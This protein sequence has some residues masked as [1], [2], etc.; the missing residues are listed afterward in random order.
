[1]INVDTGVIDLVSNVPGQNNRVDTNG[2][3]VL[4]KA[5]FSPFGNHII[6]TAWDVGEG[7]NMPRRLGS[8]YCFQRAS[9]SCAPPV[10]KLAQ[11]LY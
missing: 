5:V 10:T 3:Y 4:G 1:M 2:G 8:I 11:H 9:Q 6:Y 7:G